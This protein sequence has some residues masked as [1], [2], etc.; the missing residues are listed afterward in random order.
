M[1]VP[2][3]VTCPKWACSESCALYLRDKSSSLAGKEPQHGEPPFTYGIRL[4]SSQT[5]ETTTTT[6]TTTT[7]NNNN[8]ININININ[9]AKGKVSS[10]VFTP[11]A[12]FGTIFC[13]QT[14]Q[15]SSGG[16]TLWRARWDQKYGKCTM[17]LANETDAAFWYAT[18]GFDCTL[19]KPSMLS[20]ELKNDGF[21]S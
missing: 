19:Q 4:E 10:D 14:A 3:F 16:S 17:G 20:L 8:N 18:Y 7:N 15:Q 11:S 12:L 5:L 13:Y 9:I 6:T 1:G 21:P 2:K